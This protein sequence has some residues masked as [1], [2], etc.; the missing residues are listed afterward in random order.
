[1]IAMN[2]PVPPCCRMALPSDGSVEI[3]LVKIRIDMPFPTPR[4]VIS[5]PS[6]MIKAVPAVMISTMNATFEPVNVPAG[7]TSGSPDAAG[8]WNRNT[9]PVDCSSAST[10]VT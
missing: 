4:W 2:L 8:L 9:S 5:S 7:K 6:H 3:T 1:M 10:M